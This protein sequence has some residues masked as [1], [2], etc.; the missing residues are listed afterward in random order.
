MAEADSLSHPVRG[1]DRLVCVF[2]LEFAKV[3]RICVNFGCDRSRWTELFCCGLDSL[4]PLPAEGGNWS[5]CIPP[6]QSELLCPWQ[7][8]IV[9]IFLVFVYVLRLELTKF[10][11]M[12][13]TVS[14]LDLILTH[15][16]EVKT[17]GHFMQLGVTRF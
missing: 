2:R 14:H 15:F 16:K 17:K 10:L 4:C 12:G 1:R 7:G 8:W 9:C 3:A 11:E 13:Q 6:G 5:A